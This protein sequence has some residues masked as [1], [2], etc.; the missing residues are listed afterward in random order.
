MRLT[1]PLYH[2][3]ACRVNGEGNK[4]GKL[5]PHFAPSRLLA[6]RTPRLARGAVALAAGRGEGRGVALVG[7]RVRRCVMV[8]PSIFTQIGRE[9]REHCNG[10]LRILQANWVLS[11][12]LTHDDITR[13]LGRQ[14]LDA[15]GQKIVL[16]RQ[17]AVHCPNPTVGAAYPKLPPDDPATQR[18]SVPYR[19]CLACEHHRKAGID[20]VHY[21]HC[22]WTQDRRGGTAGAV[23]WMVRS[24]AEAVERVK[25]MGVES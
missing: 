5:A 6:D 23:A 17:R 13:L 15:N 18:W 12:A 16:L 24:I 11:S 20:Q 21:P 22:A 25:Q 4:N 3:A 19:L 9:V 14:A 7:T 1:G 2:E 8:K 10:R